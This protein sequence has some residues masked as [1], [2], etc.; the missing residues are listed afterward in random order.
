[1]K[2]FGKGILLFL[3]GG[4]IYFWLEV[5]WRGYSHWSMFLLGGLCFVL[6]G[7]INEG[8][9][10]EMPLP[11]QMLISALMITALEF[12]TGCIVNLWLGWQVWD[13]SKLHVQLLGQISLKSSVIW[14]LLSSVGIVLDD[15][16]RYWFFGE[17]RPNYRLR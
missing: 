5:L 3:V 16:L 13:Y 8:V 14:F 9:S 1:M 4:L 17:D 7:L 15:W 10:W 6:C 11:L 12:L 2:A